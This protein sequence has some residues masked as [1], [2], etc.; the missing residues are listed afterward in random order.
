MIPSFI[1]T[2]LTNT[3]AFRQVTAASVSVGSPPSSPSPLLK[4]LLTTAGL[5]KV[6]PGA[7]EAPAD[8]TETDYPTAVYQTISAGWGRLE[9]YAVSHSTLFG[10]AIRDP[11]YMDVLTAV[12]DV[13]SAAEA[14]TYGFEVLDFVSGYDADRS[15]FRV[16]IEIALSQAPGG[17][18]LPAAV[19]VPLG[20]S[21]ESS[22]SACIQQRVNRRFGLLLMTAGNQLDTLIQTADGALIGKSES[23][24]HDRL[25]VES[26]SPIES[27]GGLAMWQQIYID[28]YWQTE[29]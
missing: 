29:A 17:A 24:E 26:G 7:I 25:V 15:L 8:P 9:G 10:I 23:A 12:D 19:V 21:A 3:G 4:N 2:S 28:A 14:S 18:D 5:P 22:D 13:I 1:L 16:D 20:Y 27:P 6:R 11:E